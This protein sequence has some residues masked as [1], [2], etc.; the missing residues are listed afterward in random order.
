MRRS[1]TRLVSQMTRISCNLRPHQLN[2][3]WE[4]RSVW[5]GAQ[6]QI[7]FKIGRGDELC[8]LPP[9][10]FLPT[11]PRVQERGIPFLFHPTAVDRKPAGYNSAHTKLFCVS[12]QRPR[13]LPMDVISS[14]LGEGRGGTGFPQRPHVPD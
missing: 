14:R 13:V 12:A 9:A 3:D 4:S 11:R 5:H 6:G 2:A 10:K 1:K 7:S 8:S